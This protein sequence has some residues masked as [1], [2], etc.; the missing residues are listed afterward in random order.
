MIVLVGTEIYSAA[1]L[2]KWKL[3][4]VSACSDSGSDWITIGL[5]TDVEGRG[6]QFLEHDLC[7]WCSSLVR[8]AVYFAVTG[9]AQFGLW[10]SPQSIVAAPIAASRPAPVNAFIQD[11]VSSVRSMP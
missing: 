11:A 8:R 6:F 2:V 7:F 3:E 4:M 9:E 5:I 10:C 1:S